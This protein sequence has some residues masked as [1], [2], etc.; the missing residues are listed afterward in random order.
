M[1][2]P[3]IDPFYTQFRYQPLSEINGR[4][5]GLATFTAPK[6]NYPTQAIVKTVPFD[7]RQR[8]EGLTAINLNGLTNVV[9]TYAYY[10]FRG[11]LVVFMK[12]YV[13][14]SLDRYLMKV[15]DSGTQLTEEKLLTMM[16][17]IT[18][19][20]DNFHFH[21]FAH[22]DVKPHNVFLDADLC[23]KLGDLEHV[24]A[25][26]ESEDFSLQ[27]QHAGTPAYMSPERNA[28]LKTKNPQP[29]YNHQA[30]TDDIYALGKTFYDMCAGGTEEDKLPEQDKVLT[31]VVRAKV[32]ER[33]YRSQLA[34]LILEMMKPHPPRAEVVLRTLQGLLEALQQPISSPERQVSRISANS[35]RLSTDLRRTFPLIQPAP[36][37]VW[38]PKC[39]RCQP[40]TTPSTVKLPC[41]HCYCNA[42]L[43]KSIETCLSRAHFM[44]DVG[45]P[46]CLRP[47]PLE[48]LKT[49]SECITDAML[50]KLEMLEK[51]SQVGTCPC[52]RRTYSKVSHNP[53]TL[54]EPYN[55]TFTDCNCKG[56]KICSW[57]G[58]QGGHK[59]CKQF[60]YYR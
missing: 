29:A 50:A 27:S 18:K 8:N 13:E 14:S 36:V 16:V 47:I 35:A 54:P 25:I 59:K 46:C 12:Y 4:F 10:T 22:R 38:S 23:C 24:K 28:K 48:F 39:E 30:F 49:Q 53:R 5:I 37:P 45:C 57:C 21:R 7:P 9:Q 43:H 41:D 2:I 15:R 11:K 17:D 56:K 44:E 55:C 51:L 26:S 6:P 34:D 33:R 32:R 3:K 31:A 60:L 40:R 19:S 1:D 52:G 20:L 42:C 58:Q